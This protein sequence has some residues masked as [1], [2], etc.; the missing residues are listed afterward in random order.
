MD[1]ID[2][3]VEVGVVGID[4]V[5]ST[6]L[7]VWVSNVDV[8]WMRVD[9]IGVEELGCSDVVVCSE[10]DDVLVVDVISTTDDMDDEP[11]DEVLVTTEKEVEDDVGFTDVGCTDVE[12]TD[13]GCTDVEV[14]SGDDEVLTLDFISTTDDV[15]VVA[16]G[17]ELVTT[18]VTLEDDV[19]C[20][21]VEVCFGDD[22]MST[23]DD[24]GDVAFI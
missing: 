2:L 1:V 17:E 13:V 24:V 12:C 4:D 3:Y 14:C 18:G 5:D 19:E 20:T 16:T 23:T 9:V 10:N 15:E 22:V 6:E 7:E 21:D 11:I 8:V